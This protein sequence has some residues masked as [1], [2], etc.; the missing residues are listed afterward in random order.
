MGNNEQNGNDYE[1]QQQHQLPPQAANH[2]NGNGNNQQQ[3]QEV[4]SFAHSN[5]NNGNGNNNGNDLLGNVDS[6]RGPV[7]ISNYNNGSGHRG[8]PSDADRQ[9]IQLE[10]EE[11]NVGDDDGW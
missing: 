4:P 8:L 6:R 2:M 5:M 10:K 1:Q 11:F 9:E 3:Q 7:N